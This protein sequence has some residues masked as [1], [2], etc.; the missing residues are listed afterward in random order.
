MPVVDLEWLE[1]C[2]FRFLFDYHN[3]T[4]VRIINLPV[5]SGC[6]PMGRSL[7]YG[8]IYCMFLLFHDILFS[9]QCQEMIEDDIILLITS[10]QVKEEYKNVCIMVAQTCLIHKWINYKNTRL[11]KVTSAL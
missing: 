9:A 8:I 5:R 7:S 2:G 6:S 4:V 3:A 10:M 11:E 1:N